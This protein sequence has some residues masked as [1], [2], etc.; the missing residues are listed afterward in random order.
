LQPAGGGD[1]PAGGGL[2]RGEYRDD[3]RLAGGG[4][5]KE[6]AAV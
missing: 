4:S 5:G 2:V 3:C 1:G 6:G